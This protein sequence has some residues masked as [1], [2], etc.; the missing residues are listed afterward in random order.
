MI[1]RSVSV[2]IVCLLSYQLVSMQ[3]KLTINTADELKTLALAMRPHDYKTTVEGCIIRPN[4]IVNSV[5]QLL[6]GNNYFPAS[7]SKYVKVIAELKN[8][9]YKK[10][11]IQIMEEYYMQH[12]RQE[13]VLEMLKAA[14]YADLGQQLCKKNNEIEHLKKKKKF[15]SNITL[16]MGIV[17][18][19]CAVVDIAA[20]IVFTTMR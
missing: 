6:G 1:Y 9:T 14:V 4:A 3:E 17:A 16:V 12:H 2:V 8:D 7:V 20:L 13:C 11:S 18:G 19:C 10:Q 15:F 5:Q